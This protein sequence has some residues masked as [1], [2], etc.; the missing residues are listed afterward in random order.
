MGGG[1]FQATNSGS[2][3]RIGYILYIYI[4][5]WSVGFTLTYNLTYYILNSNITNSLHKFL[6]LC[7]NWNKKKILFATCNFVLH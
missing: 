3:E 1:G 2:E 7:I 5:L 6:N 4:P